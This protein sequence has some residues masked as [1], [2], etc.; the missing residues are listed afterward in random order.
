MPGAHLGSLAYPNEKN[1][2][3]NALH[4]SCEISPADANEKAKIIRHTLGMHII[5]FK[6]I[7]SVCKCSCLHLAL[8][9]ILVKHVTLL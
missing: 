9:K 6:C 8:K 3:V 7:Y 1:N 2:R 4:L 5:S